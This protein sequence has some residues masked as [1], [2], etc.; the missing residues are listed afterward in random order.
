MLCFPTNGANFGHGV[1]A[2]SDVGQL[3]DLVAGRLPGRTAADQI[4]V[5]KQN[6]DQGVG[7]MGLA[8]YVH[9]LAVR[10]GLGVEV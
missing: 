3:S 2:W 1:S 5:F 7:Y 9:D 8:R 10:E 6:S 4:T